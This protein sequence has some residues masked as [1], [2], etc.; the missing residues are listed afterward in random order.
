[1]HKALTLLAAGAAILA[2][3]A[4]A[5]VGGT[6]G[7]S[8][9][10]TVDTGPVAGTVGNVTGQVGKTVEHV[11]GAVNGA[12]DSTKL[13]VATREQVR[14]GAQIVD[15]QGNSVGTV[16]SIDGANAVIVD[17]GKLY[18]IPLAEL[19]SKAAS[20]TG[21]LV[22]KLPRAEIRARVQGGAAAETR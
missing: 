6:V 19:Y 21:P 12:I 3:P 5:Q 22:T 9:D 18:N 14:A 17:G 7:G 2:V 4:L 16:Q 20:V 1:M 11:D 10:T 8:V 15:T 13:V